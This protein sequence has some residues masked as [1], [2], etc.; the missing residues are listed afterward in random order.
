MEESSEDLED[1]D[2]VCSLYI[3]PMTEAD[4]N[5]KT[6]DEEPKQGEDALTTKHLQS[7]FKSYDLVGKWSILKTACG[8]LISFSNELDADKVANNNLSTIFGPMQIV[9]LHGRQTFLRQVG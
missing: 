8:Y 9:R 1:L 6:T 3:S 4:G 5:T 2:V 7:L